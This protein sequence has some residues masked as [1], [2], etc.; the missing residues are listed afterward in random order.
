[1][2]PLL[3][4]GGIGVFSVLV[5]LNPAAGAGRSAWIWQ[6]CAPL[7]SR[8]FPDLQVQRTT[9]PGQAGPHIRA[10]AA[11]G[12]RH[13]LLVGGDGTVHE[14]LAAAVE[15]GA[16]LAVLPAGTGNDFARAAGMLLPPT[17]LLLAL[18]EGH[19]RRVDLGTVHG[20]Y[21]G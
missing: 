1:M 18:A 6:R 17:R 21:F 7:A 4:S 10:A 2:R 8:L 12:V 13:V 16:A 14:A 9:G 15:T 5:L 19:E 11:A 20:Q 3:G